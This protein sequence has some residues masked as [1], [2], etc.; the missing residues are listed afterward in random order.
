MH[1][2]SPSKVVSFGSPLLEELML[3]VKERLDKKEFL[4]EVS[5][6]AALMEL[7]IYISDVRIREAKKLLV[8]SKL[9]ITQI[10]QAVGFDGSSQFSR[11]FKKIAG[12]SPLKYRGEYKHKR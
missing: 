5:A 2:F 8:T 11:T 7:L 9:N 12:T 10:A 1:C 4:Y 6:K 3:N